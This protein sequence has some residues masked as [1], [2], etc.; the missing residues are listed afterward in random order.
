MTQKNFLR[1]LVCLTTLNL[2]FSFS[3]FLFNFFFFKNPKKNKEKI[4]LSIEEGIPE[5]PKLCDFE[6]KCQVESKIEETNTNLC[7]P[8]LVNKNENVFEQS[9]KETSKKENISEHVESASLKA[10]QTTV[11]H[12]DRNISCSSDD[13][14]K[15][16]KILK[17]A[18]HYPSLSE[19]L[20][21]NIKNIT[22]ASAPSGKFKC[23][24]NA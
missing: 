11:L 13:T 2:C 3:F 19:A 5:P 17:D 12:N 21:E 6:T 4:L 24:I 1:R 22:E 20:I 9:E 14:T 16:F 15:N 23:F 10:C 18:C 7:T 8:D